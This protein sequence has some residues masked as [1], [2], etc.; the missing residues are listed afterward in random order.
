MFWYSMGSTEVLIDEWGEIFM[1]RARLPDLERSKRNLERSARRA[2][3]AIEDYMVSNC[4]SKM[5]T[6]TYARKCFSRS[7]A[8]SDIHDFVKRWRDYMGRDFPYVWVLEK[9]KDGSWHAHFAVHSGLYTE[10]FALQRLWS[11]GIVRFDERH[12]VNPGKRDMRR[13]ARYLSKYISKEFTDD[14]DIGT[15]RYEVAQGYQPGKVTKRFSTL[16]EAVAFLMMYGDYRKVWDSVLDPD[17]TGPNV[18]M[19]ESS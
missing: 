19:F 13:L 16:S 14:V 7:Q 17:W 18:F 8:V 10:K 2:R 1:E 3:R 11:H 9:H 12:V 15:H 5:W 4:L 6:V